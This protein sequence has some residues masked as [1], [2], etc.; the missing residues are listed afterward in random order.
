MTQHHLRINLASEPFRRDRPIF[1]ASVAVSGVLALLL[2]TLTWMAILQRMQASATREAIATLEQEARKLDQEQARINNVL[3]NPVNAEVLDRTVFLNYLLQ[4][5][6]LSWTKI[7]GDLETVLPHNVRIISVRPQIDGLNNVQL[8]L[9][10]GSASIEPVVEMMMKLEASP[11]F[12]QTTIANSQPPTQT[13]PLYR[14]RLT[15]NY[16]QKI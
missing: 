7:F 5:K 1:I 9:Y 16:A 2:I 14:Y 8:D 11:L 6:G 12:G 15:V 10:V 4:R 3:R 13:E